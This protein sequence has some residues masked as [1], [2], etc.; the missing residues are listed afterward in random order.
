MLDSAVII[1]AIFL[2]CRKDEA[3]YPA[4]GFLGVPSCVILL[5]SQM[6]FEANTEL[7]NGLVLNFKDKEWKQLK[8]RNA[9]IV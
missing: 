2:P 5:I 9:S 4:R 6:L 1:S 3:H 7:L 8:L